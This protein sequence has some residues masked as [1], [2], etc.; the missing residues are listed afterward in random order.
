MRGG[1]NASEVGYV[2]K[3]GSIEQSTLMIVTPIFNGQDR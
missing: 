3:E 1:K 2:E